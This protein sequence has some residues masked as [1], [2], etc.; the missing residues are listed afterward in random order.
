MKKLHYIAVLAGVSAMFD[1]AC[2]KPAIDRALT[3]IDKPDKQQALIAANVETGGKI[4]LDLNNPRQT[5]D[6]LG[7]G[8]YF[9]SG[10]IVN[11]ITN[12]NT[13]ATWLWQDLGVNVFRIVLW[14][15]G[16]EDVNDNTDPNVTD[17]SKFNFSVNTNL[18]DQITAVKKAK[19]LN[20]GIKVW[21]IVLS[22]PKFLKTNN[23]VNHGGTL[24][25]GVSNAYAEFGE[26]I[27]AHLQ[28]LKDNGLQV[29]YLSMMNE[30][31]QNA[32]NTGYESAT[33]TPSAAQAVYNQTGNWLKTKLP[34]AGV[35]MPQLSA[36][37]CIDVTHTANYASLLNPYIDLFTTHQYGGSSAANFTA[38]SNLA[39]GK[40]LYMTEWHTGFGSTAPDEL[41]SALDLVNKFHD[42]FR[43]GARGWLYFEWGNPESNFGGLLY[44]PWSQDAV[45]KKNY[46]SYKQ[47]TDSLLRKRYIP[48]TLDSIV[49]FGADNVT[50]FMDNNRAMV[51][52][53]NWNTYA[54]NRV[55]INF[56]RNISS[57]RIYRTSATENQALV[58][59]QDNVNLN[60]YLVEFP[61]K[62]FTTIQVI[63][64]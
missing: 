4:T 2:S 24:N 25:A 39:G 19:L 52:V 11:G 30:P 49:N 48:T 47:F 36:P 29:D 31:D 33:F 14:A 50:A 28:H 7:A 15:G 6:L 1:L 63:W 56:G 54:Q 40:G 42:A 12:Y 62:S 35:V 51:N 61:G 55:R 41:V 59:T 26:H 9:Y 18:V 20:P 32:D 46:Y 10:H 13:A 44:T 37:D 3:N 23:D 60:Y 16:V 45:R 17:F 38:A 34:A 22:P 64:Q 43:G 53:V 57:I 8:C 21:A 27:Y 5:V 58:W